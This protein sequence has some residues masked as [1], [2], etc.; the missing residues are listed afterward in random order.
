M[1]APRDSTAFLWP[2][3]DPAFKTRPPARGA[4]R[5]KEAR[6]RQEELAGRTE[7]EHQDPGKRSLPGRPFQAQDYITGDT[8][9]RYT[10]PGGARGAT[11]FRAR[12]APW[13]GKVKTPA[14]HS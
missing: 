6:P 4:C 14:R 8:P 12:R 2:R 1:G 13:P 9:R 3:G 11:S 10:R 5:A 7:P